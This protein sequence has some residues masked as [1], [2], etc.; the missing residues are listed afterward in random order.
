MGD[1]HRGE[2]VGGEVES[3]H[4]LINRQGVAH[5]CALQPEAAQQVLLVVQGEPG[6]LQHHSRAQIE[7]RRI[8]HLKYREKI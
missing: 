8:E 1:E 2:G 3:V 5:L 4:V 6:G 7:T